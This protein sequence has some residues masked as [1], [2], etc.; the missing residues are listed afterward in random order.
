MLIVY[1][2]SIH[3]IVKPCEGISDEQITLMVKYIDKT[4]CNYLYALEGENEGRH[5]HIRLDKD[6]N[7]KT[8]NIT[9][10]VKTI[11]KM[12]KSNKDEWKYMVVCKNHNDP[13]LLIGYICK[14]GK[15]TAKG[16]TEIVIAEARLYYEKNKKHTNNNKSIHLGNFD[17]E[18]E[19]YCRANSINMSETGLC[20][21]LGMMYISGEYRMN[22]FLHRHMK[23]PVTRLWQL[24]RTKNPNYVKDINKDILDNQLNR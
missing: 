2:M 5:M 24:R 12:K 6:T 3:I 8:D 22:Q 10:S 21:I 14:D 17:I 20:T 23:I 1:N 11:L 19:N 13:K 9:R 4:K 18:A 7:G 16:F 15:W